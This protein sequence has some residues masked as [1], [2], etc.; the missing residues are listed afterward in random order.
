[1]KLESKLGIS[2][3]TLILAMFLSAL[4]ADLRIQEANK[5]SASVTHGRVPVIAGARDIRTAMVLSVRALE[6]YMLFGVDAAS[7]SAFR[8]ERQDALAAADAPVAQLIEHS[9]HFDLG[10]DAERIQETQAGL[11]RMRDIEEKIEHLNELHTPEGSSQA[12]DMLRNQ[13]LPI[14][15]TLSASL[16]EVVNS[17]QT[18]SDAEMDR[19][20]SANHT[21]QITPLERHCPRC[22]RRRPHLLL[23]RP[24]Y[25]PRH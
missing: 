23:L 10:R 19:L 3:G 12:Y 11:A 8:Q 17:Q 21:I 14:D 24:P 20:K 25:H 7:S 18:Q 1:M 2:S 6:S 13:L 5:L 9:Q 4:I 16:R 15:A 22:P